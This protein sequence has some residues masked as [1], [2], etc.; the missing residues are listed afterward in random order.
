MIEKDSMEITAV[1]VKYLVS[2]HDRLL[3]AVIVNLM[4]FC[5]SQM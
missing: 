1:H 3:L 2:K 5:L 4:H